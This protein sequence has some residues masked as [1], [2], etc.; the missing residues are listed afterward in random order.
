MAIDV[1]RSTEPSVPQFGALS[2]SEIPHF[3]ARWAPWHAKGRAHDQAVRRKLGI[4]APILLVL[5]Q[6]PGLVRSWRR[7]RRTRDLGRTSAHWI[8]QQRAAR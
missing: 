6:M 5:V 3:G 7:P 2:E 1:P 4:A 8:A